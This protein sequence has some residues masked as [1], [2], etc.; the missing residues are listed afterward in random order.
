MSAPNILKTENKWLTNILSIV[1]TIGLM[2]SSFFLK[3][4]WDN[5]KTTQKDI[6][7]LE[8]TSATTAG[9]RFTSND[10]IAQKNL[11]DAE[12]LAMDRRLMR[13]EESLPFIRDSLGRIEASINKHLED[14]T[15]T[16]PR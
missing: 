4:C 8:I 16:I 15:K 6:Q 11:L 12:K 5:L 3:E 9:N 10:W 1:C 7:T 2:I 13:V 14:E